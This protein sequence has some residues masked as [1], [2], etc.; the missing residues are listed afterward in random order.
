MSHTKTYSWRRLDFP[1][2]EILQLEHRANSIDARSTIIDSGDGHFSL[3]THWTLDLAWRA[4]SL[5][6]ELISRSGAKTLRIERG[7]RGWIIDGHPR[8][9]LAD[10]IEIDV[11]ATPF[12]NGLA[13]HALD[14]HPGEITAL[15]V[16]ASD[17]SVQPSR[18]AYKRI[19]PRQWRYVDLGVVKGFKAILDFDEDGLV[20]RY[21]GLFERV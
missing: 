3:T 4:L 8:P 18:Q 14:H 13:L 2:L 7:A 16:D 6:L 5:D 21:E 17:L 12:C 9:D 15:Y 11:S 1:G 20:T 10:C 19:G